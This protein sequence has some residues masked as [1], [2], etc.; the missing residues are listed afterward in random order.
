VNC[1][2]EN[3]AAIGRGTAVASDGAD[4]NNVVDAIAALRDES[5]S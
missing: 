1:G 3:V 4:K 2:C 5:P